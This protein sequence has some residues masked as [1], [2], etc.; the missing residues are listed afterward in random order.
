MPR[1]SKPPLRLPTTLANARPRRSARRVFASQRPPRRT[2]Y[3]RPRSPG[4]RPAPLVDFSS[5]VPAT[6]SAPTTHAEPGHRLTPRR[7]VTSLRRP[8]LAI[9]SR[10]SNASRVYPCLCESTS[11]REA[12]RPGARRR[13][14]ARPNTPHPATTH[15]PSGQRDPT[16]RHSTLRLQPGHPTSQHMPL[17]DWPRL[18]GSH[19]AD[20]P[21]PDTSPH[22]D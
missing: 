2:D 13:R 19:R 21:I 10:R 12:T 17:R 3:P 1:H 9:T 15:R 11:H 5:H 14:M 18:R 7:A 16:V 6:P 22:A 8:W 4:Q 20:K